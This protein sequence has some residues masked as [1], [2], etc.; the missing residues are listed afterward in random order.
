MVFRLSFLQPPFFL[1]SELTFRSTP[2]GF[3]LFFSFIS[4]IIITANDGVF[5]S[6]LILDMTSVIVLFVFPYLLYLSNGV[7]ISIREAR[8]H[9]ACRG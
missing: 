3:S 8:D 5:A 7:E 1:L 9:E 4:I 2:S 6:I